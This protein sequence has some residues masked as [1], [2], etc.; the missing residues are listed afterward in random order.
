MQVSMDRHELLSL[1]WPDSRGTARC[2][3]LTRA[4]MM[5]THATSAPTHATMMP[6][7]ARMMPTWHHHRIPHRRGAAH[8]GGRRLAC[9]VTTEACL[10]TSPA[11]RK[12]FNLDQSPQWS[13]I[14][15]LVC[16]SFAM[17]RW[18]Q[19]ADR[20]WSSRIASLATTVCSHWD[21]PPTFCYPLIHIHVHVPSID[22]VHSPWPQS[23]SAVYVCRTSPLSTKEAVSMQRPE[24]R[25]QRLRQCRGRRQHQCRGQRPHQH[26]GQRP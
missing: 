9:G 17:P 16:S 18:H 4:T 24:A 21:L 7:H 25:G 23:T 19:E 13:M 11:R 15:P 12:P 5:P 1:C 8:G 10:H 14:I 3:A 22:T 20:R 2:S 26:R 6:T